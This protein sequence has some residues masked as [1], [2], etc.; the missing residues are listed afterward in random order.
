[1]G[2][3]CADL[4]AQLGHELGDVGV[5][6]SRVAGDSHEHHVLLAGALDLAAGDEALA[7][8]QQH[9]LEHHARVVGR[10]ARHV[11]AEI[12]V[13][14][15]QIE[16][17][18]DEMPQRELEG[19]GLDLLVEHHRNEQAVALDRLVAGLLADLGSLRWAINA[20]RNASSSAISRMLGH[21]VVA[22]SQRFGE[23]RARTMLAN[24]TALAARLFHLELGATTY[25]IPS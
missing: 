17:F 1:L 2:E 24:S 5:A 16:F 12:G 10:G 18:I 14:C 8:G 7:V 6:G 23:R 20:A 15:A 3:Q 13:Q 11:V 9:D 22:Q 19:A 21:P 25:E 4:R